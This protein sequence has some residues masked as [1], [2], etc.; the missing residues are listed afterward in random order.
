MR[1]VRQPTR[2]QAPLS[3]ERFTPV[4]YENTWWP[5]AFVMLA[6]LVAVWVYRQSLNGPFLFDDFVIKQAGFLAPLSSWVHGV[7]PFTYATY[8]INAHF[9]GNEPFSYHLFN[10]VFHCISGWLVFLI[11]RRLAAW[12][13][14]EQARRS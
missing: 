8:W 2:L 3:L 10:L 4:N 1:K 5:G 7:R 9:W 12:S 6:M 14:L 11:V 13:A